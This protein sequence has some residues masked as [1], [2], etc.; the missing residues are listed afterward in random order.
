MHN[1]SAL[2]P[3]SR[4]NVNNPVRGQDCVLIMLNNNQGPLISAEQ[5]R[6]KG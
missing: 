4:S 6:L 1:L 3:G 2:N 5:S